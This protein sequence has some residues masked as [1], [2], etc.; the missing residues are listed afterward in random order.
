MRLTVKLF[1]TV[2][3]LVAVYIAL[4]VMAFRVEAQEWIPPL[5]EEISVHYHPTLPCYLIVVDDSKIAGMKFTSACW[6]KGGPPEP[7]GKDDP[8]AAGAEGQRRTEFSVLDFEGFSV[9]DRDVDDGRLST[10]EADNS[11]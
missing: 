5:P 2:A 6:E 3:A 9:G 4:I 1:L 10:K 7:P 11:L 8:P